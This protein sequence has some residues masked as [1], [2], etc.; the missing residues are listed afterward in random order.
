MISINMKTYKDL[1]QFGTF[2]DSFDS[3]IS[4]MIEHEKEK[5]AMPGPSLAG[6]GQSRAAVLRLQT[7][8][9]KAKA[10]GAAAS[11]DK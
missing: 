6:V 5:A 4:R 7:A 1:T 9:T 11:S 2:Q 3:I 8:S 10:K